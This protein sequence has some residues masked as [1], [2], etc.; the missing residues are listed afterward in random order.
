MV[1][2]YEQ[3]N[4][5]TTIKPNKHSKIVA[6]RNPLFPNSELVLHQGH[7]PVSIENVNIKNFS[8][9]KSLKRV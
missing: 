5:L 6:N 9:R 4:N 3:I 2:D 8:I 1:H 7:L